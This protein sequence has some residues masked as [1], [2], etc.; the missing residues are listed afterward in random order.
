MEIIYQMLSLFLC[1]C[2]GSLL[3]ELLKISGI[4]DRGGR[5]PAKYRN[6]WYW[7]IRLLIMLSSGVLVILSGVET[8][9]VAVCIGASPNFV[10]QK[11][12]GR[13]VGL[14]R[15]GMND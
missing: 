3:S 12:Q 10:L 4:F 11:F 13:P 2:F 15:A 1:G 6:P 8:S 14:S 5:F 9:L 7:L